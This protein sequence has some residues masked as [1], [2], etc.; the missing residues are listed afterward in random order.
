MRDKE[1]RAKLGDFRGPSAPPSGTKTEAKRSYAKQIIL[2]LFSVILMGCAPELGP[3]GPLAQGR[4][5][6]E[7]PNDAW[8]AGEE[9]GP[10][11]RALFVRRTS[12]DSAD[13]LAYLECLFFD[14]Y[15]DPEE[16]V[17]S[18]GAEEQV[19]ADLAAQL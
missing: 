2:A 18:V 12:A 7:A 16:W 13:E 1:G 11:G 15:L 17:R 4:Y 5:S 14:R 9:G 8:S 10:E 19:L 3:G 6:V